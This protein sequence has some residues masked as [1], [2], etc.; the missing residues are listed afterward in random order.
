MKNALPTLAAARAFGANSPE[1]SFFEAHVAALR[2][3][4]ASQR[5]DG[6]LNA[7]TTERQLAA[8]E[9]DPAKT[10][11]AIMVAARPSVPLRRRVVFGA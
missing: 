1:R 5:A 11:A 10:V 3:Q 8:A 7:M 2:A 4:L 6:H 9:A